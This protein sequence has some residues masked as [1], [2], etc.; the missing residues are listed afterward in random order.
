MLAPCPPPAPARQTPQWE[1]RPLGVGAREAQSRRAGLTVWPRAETRSSRA[2]GGRCHETAGCNKAADSDS[3]TMET[4]GG[5]GFTLNTD[6]IWSGPPAAV[7]QEGPGVTSNLREG[8]EPSQGPALR[9]QP[10][11]PTHLVYQNQGILRLGLLQA[12]DDLAGHGAHIRP[13]AEDGTAGR[14]VPQRLG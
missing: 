3:G 7:G 6:S 14:S 11:G 9:P 12:L 1:T 2:G 10:S 13:P 8:Y 5:H 4:A